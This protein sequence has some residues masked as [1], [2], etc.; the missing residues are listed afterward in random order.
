MS[1]AY[2]HVLA[3]WYYIAD[4]HGLVNITNQN[5]SIWLRNYFY[6]GNDVTDSCTVDV[7]YR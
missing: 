7:W 1:S 6:G 2:I 3:G 5:D 4:D